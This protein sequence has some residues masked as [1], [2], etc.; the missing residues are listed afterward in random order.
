ML[1]QAFYE[2]CATMTDW[3]DEL[4]SW[5]VTCVHRKVQTWVV[6]GMLRRYVAEY[7]AGCV[8]GCVADGC[9]LPPFLRSGPKGSMLHRLLWPFCSEDAFHG[10]CNFAK[11]SLGLPRARYRR[12]FKK[13]HSSGCRKSCACWPRIG[14]GVQGLSGLGLTVFKRQLPHAVSIELDTMR[15]LK[16]FPPA[17]VKVAC[18]TF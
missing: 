15:L 13:L 14:F 6:W 18:A 8:A 2:I 9:N 7:V 12:R 5:L 11:G 4:R 10:R 3:N 1:Q 17:S 16:S